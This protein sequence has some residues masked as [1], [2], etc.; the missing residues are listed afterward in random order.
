MYVLGQNTGGTSWQL[1]RMDSNLNVVETKSFTAGT[2]GYAIMLNGKLFTSTSYDSY[3]IDKVFNFA[4]GTYTS[5]DY[6]LSGSSGAYWG[7]TFFDPLTDTIYMNSVN[8]SRIYKITNASTVFNAVGVP[9]PEMGTWILLLSG[10]CFL[11][12]GFLKSRN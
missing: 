12:P 5:V 1:N 6:T 7:D 8:A 9:V 3:T 4:T 2:L 11:V 10:F